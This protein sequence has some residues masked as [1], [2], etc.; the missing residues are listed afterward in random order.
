MRIVFS[1]L[2]L[3]FILIGC[4]TSKVVT[5][6]VKPEIRRIKAKR[7]ISKS[8]RNDTDF[9]FL[10][11]N[12]VTYKIKIGDES[13]RTL[14]G[15]L[16]LVKDSLIIGSMQIGLG[17][18]VARFYADF[19]SVVVVNKLKK[20]VVSFTYDDLWKKLR[21]KLNFYD[22]QDVICND[23]F[24]YRYKIKRRPFNNA[25][26][27]YG[28]NYFIER[29]IY[30]FYM[31]NDKEAFFEN[32]HQSKIIQDFVISSDF[33]TIENSLAVPEESSKAVFKYRLKDGL[34]MRYDK[35]DIKLENDKFKGDIS[36]KINS[37]SNEYPRMRF[38]IP[39]KYKRVKF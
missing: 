37:V 32:I 28:E 33:R 15:N 18:E 25:V 10:N 1:G 22:L 35:L 31:I 38:K 36:F 3:V 20:E 12:K 6:N 8:F 39:K 23:L 2:L 17:I 7:V 11:L 14:R 16:K 27:K 26:I 5:N 34:G 13:E 21:I 9:D 19:D 30:D 4:R 29:V 24:V